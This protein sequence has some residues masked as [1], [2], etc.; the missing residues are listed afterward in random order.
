VGCYG[1][2]YAYDGATG[3][4]EWGLQLGPRTIGSPSI[5]DLDDDG[6]LEIIVGSYDGNVGALGGSASNRTNLP[7]IFA[8]GD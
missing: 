6:T 5:G 3:H 2:I 8:G 7:L 1:K 4:V